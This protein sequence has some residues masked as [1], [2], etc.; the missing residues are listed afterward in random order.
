MQLN[1]ENY[2]ALEPLVRTGNMTIYTKDIN[3]QNWNQYYTGCLNLMKDGIEDTFVQKSKI[4]IIFADHKGCNLTIIDFFFNCIMW[5]M[6]VGAGRVIESKHLFYNTTSLTKGHIKEY[7]DK[8]VIMP[9]REVM[10]SK[11]LNNMIDDALFK[12]MDVDNF[13]LS[14]NSRVSL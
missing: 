8:Y 11:S 3:F 6:I 10:D 14:I 1:Y 4:R 2:L 5:Y 9:N 12:F 7:I 13:S